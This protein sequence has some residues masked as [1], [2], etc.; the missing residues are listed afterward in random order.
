MGR[1]KGSKNKAKGLGDTIAKVTKATGIDK[2][3]KAVAG[4]SCGCDERRE[5]LNKLFPYKKDIEMSKEQ[6]KIYERIRPML[7]LDPVKRDFVESLRTLHNEIMGT[8]LKPSNCGSCVKG[9]RTTLENIYINQCN[10]D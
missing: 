5:K 4:D 8:R 9:W 1:K 3:V 10:E 7:F 6:F 2:V